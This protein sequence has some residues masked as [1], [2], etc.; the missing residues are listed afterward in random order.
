MRVASSAVALVVK[1]RPRISWAATRPVAIS[2][3]TRAAMTVVLPE[4]APAM[5]TAGSRGAVMARNCSSLK[6][7]SAAIT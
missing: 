4:P 7:K 5:I 3:T 1:V 2:Q 6:T